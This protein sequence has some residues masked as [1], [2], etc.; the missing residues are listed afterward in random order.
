MLGLGLG[1]V[2]GLSS[3]CLARTQHTWRRPGG[4]VQRSS[5]LLLLFL[6]VVLLLFPAYGPQ[7]PVPAEKGQPLVRVWTV[8]AAVGGVAVVLLL[9]LHWV[10][11]AAGA[12]LTRG[13]GGAPEGC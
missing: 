6:V 13:C 5:K 3:G 2:R 10:G 4:I 11:L 1:L 7:P 9:L 12:T 8:C